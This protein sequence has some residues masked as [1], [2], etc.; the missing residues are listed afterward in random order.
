VER[1]CKGSHERLGFAVVVCGP[2]SLTADQSLD[3]RQLPH[4]YRPTA[5]A[6]TPLP[7]GRPTDPVSSG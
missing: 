4:G 7:Q 1:V 5:P 3:L 2:T 6:A